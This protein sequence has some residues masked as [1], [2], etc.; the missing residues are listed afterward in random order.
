MKAIARRR[1]VDGAYRTWSDGRRVHLLVRFTG[2][3]LGRSPVTMHATTD[4]APA[5]A[6]VRRRFVSSGETELAGDPVA[7]EAMATRVGLFSAFRRIGRAAKGAASLATAPVRALAGAG[8]KSLQTTANIAKGIES[9]AALTAYV[10]K[11][12]A[13]R[14]GKKG[15]GSPAAAPADADRQAEGEANQPEQEEPMTEET[16]GNPKPQADQ[17]G[18]AASL[19]RRARFSPKSARH[20]QNIAKAAAKGHPGAVVAQAAIAEARKS[21]AKA[22]PAPAALRAFSP[23]MAPAGRPSAFPA[24]ARGA[25]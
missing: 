13:W 10:T 24:W 3:N 25:A 14:P 22:P 15:G 12:L 18:K 19:L 11:P 6:A 5:R 7:T 2:G 4:L 17:V 16:S 23:S 21:Q 20:V 1:P 9:T 8:M